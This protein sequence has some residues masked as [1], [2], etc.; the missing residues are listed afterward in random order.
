MS[1]ESNL[2]LAFMQRNFHLYGLRWSNVDFK[3]WN[4]LNTAD[5][6]TNDVITSVYNL[7]FQNQSQQDNVESRIQGLFES[8]LSH[9]KGT[10]HFDQ[11][12]NEE[13]SQ[14]K[15]QSQIHIKNIE[16][17]LS[18]FSSSHQH[19]PSEQEEE[20]RL[21][22]QI[23]QREDSFAG[24]AFLRPIRYTHISSLPTPADGLAFQHMSRNSSVNMNQKINEIN[25]AYHE[26]TQQQQSSSTQIDSISL[27]SR[28]IFNENNICRGD[29][30]KLSSSG[31]PHDEGKI[32]TALKKRKTRIEND[33]T[34]SF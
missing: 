21:F 13:K 32:G 20:Y 25:E 16:P 4:T 22:Y 26:Q 34:L 2:D 24:K 28:S 7:Q 6:S 3:T 27:S 15:H 8:V 5:I 29:S 33:Q 11:E 19:M 10:S 31:N 1:L 23:R 9:L 14:D 18:L 12:Q 17:P 30:P